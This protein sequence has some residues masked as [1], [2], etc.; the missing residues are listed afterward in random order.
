MQRYISFSNVT[1]DE[2]KHY[3]AFLVDMR[4]V[5]HYSINKG[6]IELVLIDNDDDEY[7]TI[8]S[9]WSDSPILLLFMD[10]KLCR[11]MNHWHKKD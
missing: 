6:I 2:T 11:L 10:I 7:I 4:R 3:D 9:D 8:K 5:Y 1:I